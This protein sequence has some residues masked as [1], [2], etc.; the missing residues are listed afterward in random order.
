[1]VRLLALE[2]VQ[3]VI[4]TG[5]RRLR[6]LL[7]DYPAPVAPAYRSEMAAHALLSDAD[8]SA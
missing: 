7:A 1:V 3:Y 6:S 2:P 5:K 4:A 8:T